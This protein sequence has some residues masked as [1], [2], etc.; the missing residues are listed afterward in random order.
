M[1]KKNSF[2]KKGDIA[3]LREWTR[4]ILDHADF[5]SQIESGKIPPEDQKLFITGRAAHEAN[6]FMAR[7]IIYVLQSKIITWHK[8]LEQIEINIDVADKIVQALQ[9]KIDTW[10]K[11]I[12]GAPEE[13]DVRGSDRLNDPCAAQ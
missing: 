4:L 10:E 3:E 12:D 13:T 9:S 5:Q 8:I 1:A 2:F 6:I 7:Q 11:K